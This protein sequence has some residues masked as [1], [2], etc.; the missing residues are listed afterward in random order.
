MNNDK[1]QVESGKW[2]VTSGKLKVGEP[3]DGN[4]P[5]AICHHSVRPPFSIIFMVFFYFY[6][7]KINFCY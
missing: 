5:F 3:S 2:Q 7:P 6:R 1:W 4:L